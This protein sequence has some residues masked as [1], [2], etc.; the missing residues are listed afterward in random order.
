MAL[1]TAAPTLGALNPAYRERIYNYIDYCRKNDIRCAETIT[2][3]KGHRKLRPNE[4]DDPDFY[5]HVVDRNKDGVF[6]S[7]AKMHITGA[8]VVHDLVVLPTKT[9]RPGEEDYAIACAVPAN[10]PGVTIVNTT[11]APRG[12]DLRHYPVSGR[13]TTPEGFI[14]FD[15]VFVPNE[16]VFL[17]GEV[18]QSAVLAHALG[19]WERGSGVARESKAG[20]RLVGMAALL[21]DAN[22]TTK[23][24]H[25]QDMLAE[26]IMYATTSKA[27]ADAAVVHGTTNEDGSFAP[28]ELHVSTHKYY[29]VSQ[30]GHMIDLLH[31][32]AGPLT[33]AAPTMGDLE[34]PAVGALLDE[35]LG[36]P[37]FTAEQRLRLFHFLRDTTADTF[38][39]WATAAGNLS[40]GGQ[41]SQQ[42]VALRHYDMDRARAIAAASIGLHGEPNIDDI[43][44]TGI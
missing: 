13:R 43:G 44:V 42:I 23:K 6:I 39:G 20:D 9:M 14:I 10:A 37:G 24:P 31:E 22:G 15:R 38:G 7:G 34:D 27:L 5:V 3:A 36:T 8:A 29:R 40:G 12:E 28:S 2:D 18:A 25:V 26:L 19:L 41:R 33:V 35:M 30:H 21:A 17:D 11:Y 1:A 4:Q 32:I 16:R